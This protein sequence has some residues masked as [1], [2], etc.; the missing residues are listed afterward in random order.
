MFWSAVVHH[1]KSLL[2][3]HLAFDKLYSDFHFTERNLLFLSKLV[4]KTLTLIGLNIISACVIEGDGCDKEL[5]MCSSR[6]V[7]KRMFK[8][9]V[10]NKCKTQNLLFCCFIHARAILKWAAYM[11]CT[12]LSVCLYTYNYDQKN[13]TDLPQQSCGFLRGMPSCCRL[14]PRKYR[15]TDR[16]NVCRWS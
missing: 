2:T 9:K 3:G 15:S 6:C 12:V 10:V 11:I 16:R 14:R 13:Y 4:D 8:N 5:N 1:R 7:L